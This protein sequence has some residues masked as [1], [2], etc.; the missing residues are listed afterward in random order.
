MQEE[1]SFAQAD[2]GGHSPEQ[3]SL[4]RSSVGKTRFNPSREKIAHLRKLGDAA[5]SC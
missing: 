3:Q 2:E 4:N 5:S 1:S